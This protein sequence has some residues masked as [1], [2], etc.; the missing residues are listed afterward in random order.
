MAAYSSEAVVS[1]PLAVCLR[2]T[3]GGRSRSVEPEHLVPTW[4]SRQGWTIGYSELRSLLLPQCF[5]EID[6]VMGPRIKNPATI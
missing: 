3:Q 2:V 4:F 5:H 6:D 1:N